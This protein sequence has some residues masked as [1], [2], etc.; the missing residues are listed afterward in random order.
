M[1]KKPWICPECRSTLMT[2]SA[3]GRREHVGHELGRDGLT[4]GGLA[5]LARVAVVGA[6]RGDAL[7]RGPLGGVDHDEVL[8]ERVV[9]GAGVG[10][11]NEDVAATDGDVVLAVDLA[12]GEL[13]QVRLAQLDAQMARDVAG[14]RRMRTPGD[15]LEAT[16]RDQLHTDNATAPPRSRRRAVRPVRAAGRPG[17]FS[18]RAPPPPNG[19]PAPRR[20]PPRNRAAARCR[21]RCVPRH[22]WWPGCRRSPTPPRPS[23]TLVSVRTLL[24]PIS[25]PAPTTQSPRRMTPGSRETSASRCTSAST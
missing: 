19:A 14:Q 23:P 25:A 8:H 11:H 2:R 9:H 22:R 3:P 15:Q 18:P 20:R 21:R 4:T 13:A 10:L 17:P 5:V 24:G 12:V 16:P 7:G 6:D 1:S